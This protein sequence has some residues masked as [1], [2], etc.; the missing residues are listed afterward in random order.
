M[1][2]PVEAYPARS[3]L[4]PTFGYLHREGIGIFLL[5]LPLLAVAVPR[6][7]TVVLAV[8]GVVAL[9]SAPVRRRALALAGTP[10]GLSAIGLYVWYVI[11]SAWAPPSDAGLLSS[12]SPIRPGVLVLLGIAILAAVEEVA[13]ARRA[14]LLSWVAWCGIVLLALFGGGMAVCYWIPPDVLPAFWKGESTCQPEALWH[15]APVVA[16]LA[17][18][19]GVALWR[20]FG[21][22]VLLPLAVLAAAGIALHFRAIARGSAL[23]GLVAFVLVL[24]GGRRVGIVIG[25]LVAAWV[26]A[27]PFVLDAVLGRPAVVEWLHRLPTSW[28]ERTIIWT[29]TI[30]QIEE[31]PLLG[32]GAGFSRYNRLVERPPIILYRAGTVLTAPSE[33]R[34]PHSVVLHVWV[35]TGAVGAVI[36]AFGLLSLSL[37]AARVPAPRTAS[38]GAIGALVGW[39]AFANTDWSMADSL[40]VATAWSVLVVA[41]ALLRSQSSAAPAD[42]S[43]A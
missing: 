20:R 19:V 40:S 43:R 13:S 17:A 2:G 42:L 15:A 39:F 3:A 23:L 14:R 34:D 5:L 25:A 1:S 38:A 28:Q 9:T 12:H 29:T 32:R 30:G 6:S 35:E 4:G 10:A 31:T 24:L 22:R 11:G 7:L 41:A 8:A 37:A 21:W 33:F 18:P 36:L 16:I 27:A 26:L